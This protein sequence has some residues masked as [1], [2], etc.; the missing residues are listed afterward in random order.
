MWKSRDVPKIIRKCFWFFGKHFANR[1]NFKTQ[2]PTTPSPLGPPPPRLTYDYVSTFYH[3][4]DVHRTMSLI[5]HRYWQTKKNL[6]TT[7]TTLRGKNFPNWCLN[8]NW[9]YFFL[10]LLKGQKNLQLCMIIQVLM[11][12]TIIFDNVDMKSMI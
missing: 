10:L 9:Q 2:I 5:D 4:N 6:V 1:I 7:V 11:G 12:K 3:I 8:T